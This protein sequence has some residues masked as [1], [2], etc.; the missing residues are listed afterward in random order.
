M[1]DDTAPDQLTQIEGLE[2]DR[3]QSHRMEH[4]AHTIPKTVIEADWAQ[5]RDQGFVMIKGLIPDDVCDAI[6]AALLPLLSH[7]GRNPFEGERT[8]R[9]YSVLNKTRICDGLVEHPRILALL[10][11]LFAPNYLLSQ[12]QVINILPG[13]TRQG[14]HPDDGFYPV[15]R[16]RP[17]LG[18]ATVWAIDDFTAENGATHILPRSD[19]WDDRP[20]DPADEQVQ[21]VMPKGSVIFYGGTLWHGGGANRSADARLA[22]TAQYCEPWVR[23]QENFCLSVPKPIVR[24]LSPAIQ[25]MIG[26]SVIPPFIG[27]VDGMHPKRLL[28]D[29]Y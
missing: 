8:Q 27:M 20:P 16:P 15:P 25:S 11:R 21:A 7:T 19:Q 14:L 5:L 10:D 29:E 12:L 13:E 9:L 4:D 28:T 18:A 3:A 24:E 2:T 23:P 22:V 6:K 17:P 1:A 26:Y